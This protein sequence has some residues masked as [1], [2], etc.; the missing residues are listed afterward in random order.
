MRAGW[1]SSSTKSL[2]RRTHIPMND[3]RLYHTYFGGWSTDLGSHL[4]LSHAITESSFL[5]KDYSSFQSYDLRPFTGDGKS[6]GA[7]M[8]SPPEIP[9]Y[10]HLSNWITVLGSSNHLGVVDKSQPTPIS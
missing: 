10:I 9:P 6:T 8:K 3:F 7:I 5:R 4:L 2:S 1:E